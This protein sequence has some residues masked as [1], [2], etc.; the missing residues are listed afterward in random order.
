[1]LLETY[2]YILIPAV[3]YISAT[4]LK[5]CFYLIKGKFSVAR[6]LGTGGM[7]SGHSALVSSLAAAIG[8]NEGIDSAVFAVC[9]VFSAIVIYDAMNIRFQSGLHAQAINL[10][11]KRQ[12]KFNESLGHLPTE[13]LAGSMLGILVA[14]ILT[15]I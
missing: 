3:A 11:T 15:Q 6:T 9:L 10:L 7:P 14:V 12:Q 2:I 5:A 8:M 1:M 4:V 13:A